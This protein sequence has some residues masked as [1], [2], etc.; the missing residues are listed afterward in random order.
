MSLTLAKGPCFQSTSA[1]AFWKLGCMES[2]VMR[3]VSIAAM[4][5]AAGKAPPIPPAPE[6]DDDE[7]DE[8]V[9]VWLSPE[10]QPTT[11]SSAVE[12]MTR[13]K[14]RMGHSTIERPTERCDNE[15]P[16]GSVSG[17]LDLST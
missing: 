17:A 11:E 12:A 10:E 14:Q 9:A 7:E 1:S 2:L 8:D 4:M 15:G 16:G 3:T 13:E 6:E 5:N